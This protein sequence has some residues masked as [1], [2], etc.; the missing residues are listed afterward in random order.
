MNMEKALVIEELGIEFGRYAAAGC[1][2]YAATWRND[3]D[4]HIYTVAITRG[5]DG[6]W[7]ASLRFDDREVG[8]CS[9]AS[10]C[11]CAEMA[12]AAMRAVLRRGHRKTLRALARKAER[13]GE[14]AE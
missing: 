8:A 3:K 9:A 7:R 10:R 5:A 2:L 4:S 13:K 14:G 6:Q 11:R 1:E 12:V